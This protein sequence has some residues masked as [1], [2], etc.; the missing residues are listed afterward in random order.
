MG[1]D[2]LMHAAVQFG[3]GIGI[4]F[5]NPGKGLRARPRGERVNIPLRPV[6]IAQGV[7]LLNRLG[8]KL[9]K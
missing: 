7:E 1:Y 8:M 6:E 4:D 2:V 9:G 3:S 5:T